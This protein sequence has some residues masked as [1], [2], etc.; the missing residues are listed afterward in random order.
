M[1]GAVASP[2]L[3]GWSPAVPGKR[4][5][6]FAAL[7]LLG[8]LAAAEGPRV[9][10]SATPAQVAVGETVAVD[11]TYAWPRGWTV[12]GE[13]DPGADFRPLFI[14]AAPPPER[15]SDGEG[16]RRRFRYRVAATRSGAWALPRPAF[17]ATGPAGAV[18]AQAAETIV[19]VGTE[20]A[21]PDLPAARPP[22]VRP[23]AG[24]GPDRRPWWWLAGGSLAAAGLFAWW[25]LRRRRQAAVAASALQ[26]FAAES[27]QARQ[28][29]DAREVGTRLSLAVRRY[30]GSVWGFDGPGQTTREVAATLRR[31]GPARV[32]EDEAAALGRLLGRLDDLRWCAGEVPVEAMAELATLAEAWVGGVQRRLDAEA[33][34]R[35]AAKGGRTKG[36]P[37]GSAGGAERG[38]ERPPVQPPRAGA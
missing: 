26:I 9:E 21:P 20:S 5:S 37:G 13:P 32:A 11:V 8:A 36:G 10:L 24:A 28:A 12:A 35:A 27:A 2:Q 1:A 23:P 33:A 25:A 16:E 30:A 4:V 17:T 31:L 14:T 22:L 29:G 34:A 19:Q 7:L 6:V 18:R 15:S 3:P 38:D